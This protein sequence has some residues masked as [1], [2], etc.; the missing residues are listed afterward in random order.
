MTCSGVP[1]RPVSMRTVLSSPTSRYWHMNRS[2]RS[3]SMRWTSGSIS[4]FLP[5]EHSVARPRLGERG[6]ARELIAYQVFPI[7]LLKRGGHDLLLDAGRDDDDAVWLGED[8]VARTHGDAAAADWD[9]VGVD[10]QASHRVH[11]AGSGREDG[12]AYLIDLPPVAH[13]AVQDQPPRPARHGSGREQLA[14]EGGAVAILGRGHHH[15]ALPEAVDR[16]YLE[17]VRIAP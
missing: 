5:S 12:E 13:Q 4:I 14:P 11:R 1:A 8:E 6:A 17:R 7:H 15:V 3:D 16:L 2:P 10:T 9:A